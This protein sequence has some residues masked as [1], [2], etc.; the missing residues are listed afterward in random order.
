MFASLGSLLNKWKNTDKK[1]NASVAKPK[2]TCPR[3]AQTRRT[4]END[5][6]ETETEIGE[7]KGPLCGTSMPRRPTMNKLKK[8]KAKD[9][10]TETT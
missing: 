9:R 5:P 10:P 6:K 8:I 2:D 4:R 1:D 3:T 7:R